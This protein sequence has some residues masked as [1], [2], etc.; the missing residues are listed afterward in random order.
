MG[1]VEV[2][3]ART[4]EAVEALRPVWASLDVPNIDA[5]IDYFL[6]VVKELPSA[7]RPHVLHIRADDRDMLVVARIENLNLPLKLGYSTLARVRLRGLILSFDGVLGARGR[8]DEALAFSKLRDAL[9]SGDA[10]LLIARNLDLEGDRL[11]AALS[12]NPWLFRGHGQVPSHRWVIDVSESLEAFLARRTASTR[13]KLR[14]EE[15]ELFK[16]FDGDVELRCF[17]APDDLDEACRDMTTVA[18]LTYQ[19][20]L[21]AAFSGVGLDRALLQLGLEMGWSRVWVL[22][23]GGRPVAFWPGTKY[24]EVFAVGTPGFDPAYSGY[25]VGR[26]AMMKMIE[27]LSGDKSVK[28]VD[29]GQG[30]AEYKSRFGQALR[31]ER[32]LMVAAPRPWPVLVVGVHSLFTLANEGARQMAHSFK[33][34]GHLKTAW[35]RRGT[36]IATDAEVAP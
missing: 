15:R 19:R 23:C 5:D 33:W 24:A 36:V 11:D 26:F 16:H 20:K 4:I 8:A 30:E 14:R 9:A 35:R 22:Y 21:G 3:V 10:D 12:V 28:I 13:K 29:F 7:V 18:A 27:G 6:T 31:L 25:A 17:Q 32:D 34:I 1:T 2:A